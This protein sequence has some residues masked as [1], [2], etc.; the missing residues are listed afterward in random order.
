MSRVYKQKPS[1]RGC[2]AG[3][4]CFPLVCL[5]SVGLSANLGLSNSMFPGMQINNAAFINIVSNVRRV[6]GWIV[7]TS[8]INR[9][10]YI[11]SS[12]FGI[13][14]LRQIRVWVPIF[15]PINQ[16]L[17]IKHHCNSINNHT[18][19]LMNKST[20]NAC[21][22]N[23]MHFIII[24]RKLFAYCFIINHTVFNFRARFFS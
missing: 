6:S 5:K 13:I 12:K 17:R 23:L 16:R 1:P 20:H 3:S 11:K 18:R 2:P 19:K 9:L 8:Q 22:L 21:K 14:R 10:R 24:I 15:I 4:H 7:S